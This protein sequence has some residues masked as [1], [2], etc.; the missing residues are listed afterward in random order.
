MLWRLPHDGIHYFWWRWAG[1]MARL[2]QRGP[3]WWC[4]VATSWRDAWW[5]KAVNLLY[6]TTADSSRQRL[7]RGPRFLGKRGWDELV[8]RHA[9]RG[10]GSDEPCQATPQHRAKWLRLEV[11]FVSRV[12]RREM[13][14]RRCVA[15]LRRVAHRRCSKHRACA[16]IGNSHSLCM[17][18]VLTVACNE[19]SQGDG[20]L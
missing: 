15:R 4:V 7:G 3:D 20:T 9:E 2:G 10:G 16:G 12:T 13:A 18:H 14:R 11:A 17:L 1:H 8:Q 6:H 19:A 5:R